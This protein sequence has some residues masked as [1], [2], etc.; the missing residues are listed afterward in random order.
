M[1]SI[2][3][4]KL[5]IH[6]C[7]L[8]NKHT[9]QIYQQNSNRP[10]PKTMF[11]SQRDYFLKCA[12]IF[13]EDILP[14]QRFFQKTGYK[15]YVINSEHNY[16]EFHVSQIRSLKQFDIEVGLSTNIIEMRDGELYIRELRLDK[17]TPKTFRFSE[18]I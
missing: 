6:Y 16:L 12:K 2:S 4:F 1:P 11:F 17:I 14:V 7:S 9:G 8:E 13:G 3:G 18:A 5:G 10:I 15:N